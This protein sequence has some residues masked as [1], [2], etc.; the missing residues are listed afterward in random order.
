MD[1]GQTSEQTIHER[2]ARSVY[3]TTRIRGP[4]EQGGL[5]AIGDLVGV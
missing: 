5:G 2:N 3:L 4:V 1:A